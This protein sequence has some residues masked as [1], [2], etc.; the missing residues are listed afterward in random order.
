MDFKE[1][2]K[3][4]G[5]GHMN[6]F[7][8]SVLVM[9][10]MGVL[11]IILYLALESPKA[12]TKP[13]TIISSK[14]QDLAKKEIRK[15]REEEGGLWYE[16][17]VIV[18]GVKYQAQFNDDGTILVD[19]G[20]GNY[21]DLSRLTKGKGTLVNKDRALYLLNDADK[22][23]YDLNPGDITVADEDIVKILPDNK[24]EGYI[25]D[26]LI[27]ENGQLK[28]IGADGI[29][30]N[31]LE[32]KIYTVN[33]KPMKYRNGILVPLDQSINHE[34]D[35][36]YIAKSGKNGKLSYYK[37]VNGGLVKIQ[38]SDIP[39]NA[40]VFLDGSETRLVDGNLVPLEDYQNSISSLD[41]L[42]KAGENDYILRKLINGEPQYFKVTD[43]QEIAIKAEDVP[44]HAIVYYKDKPYIKGLD[45]KLTP[46]KK[47]KGMP[48][49]K[50][51]KVYV[52]GADGKPKIAK[53][54]EMIVSDGKKYQA[55]N[56]KVYELTP[57]EVTELSKF[58]NV[59]ALVDGEYRNLANGDL[60][61]LRNGEIVIRN[62][63]AYRYFNGEFYLLSPEE[64][65]AIKEQQQQIQ[66]EKKV[67]EITQE[68]TTNID[69]VQNEDED[70]YFDPS[71]YVASRS[72]MTFRANIPSSDTTKV[73]NAGL[74]AQEKQRQALNDSLLAGLNNKED[75]PYT[76]QNNQAG[77][78]SW[79]EDQKNKDKDNTPTPLKSP[80]TALVG[81][82]IDATLTTG[83]NSDLPGTITA[84]VNTPVYDTVTH[85][86]LLIPQGT[87]LIGAYDSQVS[88]GQKRVLMAWNILVFP[89]GRKVNISGMQGVDLTGAAGMEGEV[90]NHY[91]ELFKNVAMMSIFGAGVQYASGLTAGGGGNID[92]IQLIA[93]SIGQQIGQ[94][95][96]QLIQ[97]TL[98]IQP[99]I[100]IQAGERF[101]V[102]LS[103]D[104]VFKGPYKY[105]PALQFVNKP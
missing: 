9:F 20:H 93:A 51:G 81:T 74:T 87:Q 92:G 26:D 61:K 83:I 67:E 18:N 101:K 68:Q 57:E 12:E 63:A 45:G 71:L 34:P 95:G 5:Y 89:D 22:K 50:G 46:L 40:E 103:G 64:I 27:Y 85:N 56:G 44:N 66:A 97:K 39:N 88:Y 13:T 82:V 7:A 80:F 32:G 98:N 53:N 38:K 41:E 52:V 17:Y 104:V 31:A 29:K 70:D 91:Y 96:I 43:G 2:K 102:L 23:L 4:T 94:T 100:T 79:L 48:F 49:V 84:V 75:T 19:R 86:Y 10:F 37:K 90:D 6:P 16:N 3:W 36:S 59:V 8:K 55:R 21:V 77:K 25:G 28:I 30:R 14:S 73:S 105:E 58:S 76:E 65:Q 33:N 62:G 35:G 99:T 69:Q 47:K 42:D 15:L 54:Y 1:F 24:F 11:G 72:S 60:K 78:K